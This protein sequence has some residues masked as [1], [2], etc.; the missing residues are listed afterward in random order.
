MA[1]LCMTQKTSLGPTEFA[2]LRDDPRFA[3]PA[4]ADEFDALDEPRR[5]FTK[6]SSLPLLGLEY[7]HEYFDRYSAKEQMRISVLGMT[8][9]TARSLLNIAF[10]LNHTTRT[11]A[12]TKKNVS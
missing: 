6:V 11:A 5:H 12:A 9:I 1:R 4:A 2:S 3:G 10:R 8:S 7:F